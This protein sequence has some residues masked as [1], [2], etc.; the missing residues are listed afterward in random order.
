MDEK[1]RL[2][3]NFFIGTGIFLV[4]FVSLLLVGTFFDLDISNA[5]AKPYLEDGKYYTTN[6]F[7]LF[8]EAF[9]YSLFYLFVGIA[10]SIGVAYSLKLEEGDSFLFFKNLN[11]KVVKVLKWILTIGFSVITLVM[12]Y[13][14]YHEIFSN[15]NKY[16]KETS[17][18]GNIK[19]LYLTVIEFI[20]GAFTGFLLVFAFSRC[21]KETI[22]KLFNLTITMYLL[23]ALYLIFIELIKTPVGRARFRTLN[24]LGDQSLYTPW[25]KLNGAR[26]LNAYKQVVSGSLEKSE[27]YLGV[28][29]QFK[30]FP[31]GHTYSA[32][33]SFVLC[34]VPDLFPDMKKRN[35]VICYVVPF[36]IGGG[37]AIGRIIA[38]AHY[39]TDVL[40]GGSF[41]FV[42]TAIIREV[43]ILKS[44]HFKAL[45]KKD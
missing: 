34:L 23:C 31:S 15:C 18:G 24:V 32:C 40:V 3:R 22:N 6:Q 7:A 5:L 13:Y 12:L 43:L 4:L 27:G 17:I 37:V 10:S 42:F 8:M 26:T 16:L 14:N 38:G 33:M 11:G 20:Q 44:A 41:A 25:Y 28:V 19:A 1:K 36:L 9:G 30:S 2:R 21:S 29:D 39:L 35:K 45:F